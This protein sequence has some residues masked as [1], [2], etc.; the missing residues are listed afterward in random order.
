MKK[1]VKMHKTRIIEIYKCTEITKNGC[2]MKGIH[3]K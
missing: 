3:I 2:I 1:Q